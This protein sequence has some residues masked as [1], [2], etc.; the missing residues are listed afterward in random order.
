MNKNPNFYLN[1][2]RR[3]APAPS[4][5][6]PIPEQ[7]AAGEIA[8]RLRIILGRQNP[9][10]A[11]SLR[12]NDILVAAALIEYEYRGQMVTDAELEQTLANLIYRKF[13]EAYLPTH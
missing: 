8:D 4:L 5:S 12:E 11:L 13:F 1:N 3:R 6:R 2:R 7:E 9:S 10:G